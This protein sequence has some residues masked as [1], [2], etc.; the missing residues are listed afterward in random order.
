[1]IGG[2]KKYGNISILIKNKTNLNIFWGKTSLE[3]TLPSV[4]LPRPGRSIALIWGGRS[5][6]AGG[7]QV[8]V[9]LHNVEQLSWDTAWDLDAYL[10]RGMKWQ[11]ESLVEGIKNMEERGRGSECIR[12]FCCFFSLRASQHQPGVNT[13][14]QQNLILSA[15]C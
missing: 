10:V 5:V 14:N 15:L 6:S 1:M 12:F 3:Y 7:Y 9:S 8:A 13:M 4:A 2:F 11:D